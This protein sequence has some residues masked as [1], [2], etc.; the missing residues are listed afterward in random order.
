MGVTSEETTNDCLMQP[1]KN[2]QLLD[3]TDE[4]APWPI[5]TLAVGQ[6]P[7]NFCAKG[8]GFGVHE[9]NRQIYALFY[10]KLMLVAMCNAGLQ[11]WDI[12][13]PYSPR[14]VAYL[15]LAPNKN[16]LESC[17]PYQGQ[18]HHCRKATFSDLGEVDGRGYIYNF[19]RAGSGLTILKLTG[20]A[21]QV[22]TGQPRGNR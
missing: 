1:W 11:V 10:G 6:F 16:T 5:T 12:R 20:A 4:R 21:M 18:A 17:G 2:P 13:D 22:V 7:G 14:R 8:S 3:I 19:D 15:I 9:L